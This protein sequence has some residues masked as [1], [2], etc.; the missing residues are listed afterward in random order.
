MNTKEDAYST[1]KDNALFHSVFGDGGEYS[2]MQNAF[3]GYSVDKALYQAKNNGRNR[4]EQ[5]IC[6]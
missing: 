2:K 4:V 3:Y 5:I 1:L 6:G